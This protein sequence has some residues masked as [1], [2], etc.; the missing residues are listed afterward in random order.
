MKKQEKKDLFFQKMFLDSLIP[1]GLIVFVLLAFS[2]MLLS[3][4]AN[5]NEKAM[6][7][8]KQEKLT[9]MCENISNP[10]HRCDPLFC[11]G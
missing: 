10:L 5:D 4:N 7:R 8:S 2:L 9:Q 3:K 1:V 6:V 11:A